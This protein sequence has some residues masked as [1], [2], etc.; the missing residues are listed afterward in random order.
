MSYSSTEFL[1]D[2]VF[3]S[4]EVSRLTTLDSGR[5]I[6][7]INLSRLLNGHPLHEE[8]RGYVGLIYG[9]RYKVFQVSDLINRSD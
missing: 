1:T 3:E 6:Q 8:C 7:D 5:P 2:I 9:D 4:V